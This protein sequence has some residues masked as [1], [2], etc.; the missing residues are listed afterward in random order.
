LAA[1]GTPVITVTDTAGDFTSY[2]VNVSSITLT[3]TD[4][5]VVQPLATSERVDFTQLSNLSELLN[6]PA[7]AAGTY[8][9]AAVTLDFTNAVISVDVGGQSKT[10]TVVD[11]SGAAVTTVTLTVKF[12][13]G[14]PLVITQ[15]QSTRLALNF[16][17]A[18]STIVDPTTLRATVKPFVAL[19]TTPADAKTIRARGPLLTANAGGGDYIV[20]L[21]PFHD[22][23]S[24]LGALTVHTDAQTTYNINGQTYSGPAGLTAMA[25]LPMNTVTVAFGS[26]GSLSTITPVLNATQ[27]YAGASVESAIAD[28]VTGVVTKRSADS[29]TVHGATLHIRGG[30]F[31]FSNN[32]TVNIGN[33]TLVTADG[34][35]GATGLNKLSVSVGQHID[36]SGQATVDTASNITL[37]ATAGQVRLAPTR[38][39]G[40]LN[41]ATAGSLSLNLQSLDTY[42]PSAFTFTG[43]GSAPA[44]DAKPASYAVNT[45]SIDASA[46][47][48]QTLL[49]VDGFVTPFGSA[50]PGF[51]ATAITPDSSAGA[52]LSVEWINTGATAPF[53]T[54]GTS[55]LVIDRANANL[56]TTHLIRIGPKALDLTTLSASPQIVPATAGEFAV[57]NATGGI[58]VF[59]GFAAFVTQLGTTFNGSAAAQKL[60]AV[61]RYDAA[62]NT[63]T[64]SSISLVIK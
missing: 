32:A 37:D 52:Q 27:V 3:R 19:T 2:I 35:P 21:R 14:K 49:Q 33:S 10:A 55:S 26:L 7:I 5:A 48:L 23:L 13:P 45:G 59:G 15:G 9:S 16:D 60:V 54:V 38:I 28:H 56:G 4:G 43:T 20:N 17:L 46:T 58:S 24:S 47:P 36:V 22:Q 6:A 31:A 62:S 8:T 30:T 42:A 1:N 53:S 50:S 57:G 51:N 29:L 34:Q 40:L 44:F 61:G 25:A 18:A 39:W 63:F 11:S 12:D 64:A 41:S